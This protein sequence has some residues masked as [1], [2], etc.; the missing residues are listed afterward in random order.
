M[1]Y[2][3]SIIWHG[4]PDVLIRNDLRKIYKSASFNTLLD[5]I[6]YKNDSLISGGPYRTAL[7]QFPF[8]DNSFR[9]TYGNTAH[10]ANEKQQYQ[11]RLEGFMDKWSAWSAE[12]Q[13]DFTNLKEG[14]YTFRVRSKTSQGIVGSE[15]IFRFEI[16]P[17]WHRSWWAYI[18]YILAGIFGTS[19]LV[20]L[21]S[22]QLKKDKVALQDVVKLRTAELEVRNEQLEIQRL[23]LS[24]QTTALKEMDQ[25]KSRLFANISHE[26]RTPLTLIKGPLDRLKKSPESQLTTQHVEMM[27][28][29]A[30]RL[31]RLVNQILDLS[32]LAAKDLPLNLAEGNVFKSVRAVASTFSS[33][34]ADRNL[35]YQIL[36]PDT[37]LWAAFDRD[38]LEKVI[39]N[40]LSNAFKFT[41]DTG[42]IKLKVLHTDGVLKL[43]VSDTGIGIPSTETAHIFDR[44]YQIDSSDTK[45]EEGSG[46]GLALVKELVHLMLGTIHVDSTL[47]L[48]STFY[49]DLPMER[50]NRLPDKA[51]ERPEILTNVRHSIDQSNTKAQINISNR[52]LPKILIVEDNPDM[53]AFITESLEM[54]YIILEADNGP[55]GLK[56]AIGKMPDLII[57]DL[58]MP[59]MDGLELCEIIKKDLRISHIPVV[60]LTAKAGLENKLEGLESGADVYLTKPFHAKELLVQINRLIENRAKLRAKF[61]KHQGVD[62]KDLELSSLDQQFIEKVMEILEDKYGDADFD[63]PQMHQLLA[64]SR[65]QLHRKM[66]AMT[67]MAPG[68]FIRHF[69]LKR[70]AQ[71]LIQGENVTQ[72]AYTVGFNNLSYFARSFR[73]LHGLSPTEYAKQHRDR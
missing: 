65:T 58:M 59:K 47:N 15:D 35:D 18:M 26:F 14:G 51:V 12:K 2:D 29:N 4:G 37:Q 66:K 53:R 69:R 32:R 52:D 27:D 48:G 7:Y 68:E 63:V 41:D 1:F 49:I 55:A 36:V 23:Q 70:A 72:T 50:L 64:M 31:L 34:A 8:S 22:R 46:V 17:P 19:A 56:I 57:T 33:H 28:R 3:D 44:F 38:K 54:Q 25:F 43:E 73:A 20:K 6:F 10:L 30:N 60:I 67:G 62:P 11:Y 9:F 45:V 40:L 42:T 5:K 71:I 24:D 13:R 39:Y 16:R 21:R 61:S